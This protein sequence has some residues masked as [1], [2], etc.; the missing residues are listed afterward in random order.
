MTKHEFI[1][2]FIEVMRKKLEDELPEECSEKDY[3]SIS[4]NIIA[5]RI[6]YILQ[7][8]RDGKRDYKSYSNK[9]IE[10]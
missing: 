10:R 6:N 8:M 1:G 9:A 4:L 7:G 2:Y 5:N 3:T